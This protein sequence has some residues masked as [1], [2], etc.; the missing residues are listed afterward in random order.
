MARVRKTVTFM[1]EIHDTLETQRGGKPF[2]TY[3][4]EVLKKALGLKGKKPKK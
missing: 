3:L 4:N 1:E 2:S